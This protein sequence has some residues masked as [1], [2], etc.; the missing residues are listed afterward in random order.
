MPDS[1]ISPDLGRLWRL[2]SGSRLGRPAGLDVERVVRTA[3]E[4]ADRHG[5]EGVALAKVAAELGVTK[6]SLYPYLGSKAELF[7]LMADFALGP[8]P[9]ID[10]APG[11]WRAGLSA[12]ASAM[13]TMYAKHPW[14]PQIPISGPPRGPNTIG[15]MESVL[16]QL[17]STGLAW[18]TKAGIVMLVAGH[19]RQ[20]GL[21]D[22]HVSEAR[23]DTG[24]DRTAAARLYRD[25]LTTLV[26]P[27]RFPESA[28]LLASDVFDPGR[29]Q[30]P[31]HDFHFGLNLIL[32]G[33][34]AAIDR[35]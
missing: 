27:A 15:W 31:D 26:D 24:L 20:L 12:W 3:V 35:V 21:F 11:Q 2:P 22:Q 30:S 13:R 23:H 19:V 7:E 29:A 14:L 1:P 10:T 16:R 4:L 8:V 25:S 34:A 5:L 32:D 33:V 6:M 9:A 28:G 18:S 17:H